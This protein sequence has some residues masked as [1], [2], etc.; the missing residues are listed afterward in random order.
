MKKPAAM[1]Y[2]SN[3]AFTPNV[4]TAQS[5]IGSCQGDARMDERG[6]WVTRVTPGLTQSLE[7]RQVSFSEPPAPTARPVYVESH[8]L[9][10]IGQGFEAAGV[11]MRQPGGSIQNRV[12]EHFAACN[13]E[14]S[15]LRHAHYS[16]TLF[17]NWAVDR[18]RC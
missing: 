6:P 15:G 17:R 5:R 9:E 7:V 3:V 1:S 2:P 13:A 18:T 8:L 14:R 4:K 10:L 16:G 11:K 12:K